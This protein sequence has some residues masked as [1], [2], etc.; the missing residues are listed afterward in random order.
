M[1]ASWTGRDLTEADVVSDTDPFGVPP[2]PHE[3]LASVAGPVNRLLADFLPE[4]SR[5]LAELDPAL[6]PLSDE[7]SAF[8]T[9]GGK[10]LRPA[11]VYWGYRAT[12][13][14]HD[15]GLV[16]PAAAVELF[17]AFA[18]V[19]DDVMD[20]GRQRRGRP[21]VHRNMADYHHRAGL[22]GDSDW[23]GVGAAVVVGDL[24]FVWADALMDRAPLALP[25]VQRAWQ[26]F[27]QLRAEVMAGQYLDLRLAD[28][29]E[30]SEAEALRVTLLKSGRYTVTRPLQLGAA[31][32]DSDDVLQAALA[33]YGDAVGVAF[34]LRDDVLGVFGDPAET[35]KAAAE[36]VREG[37][38][39]PLVV[40]ALEL[41]TP[42]GRRV[43]E[44]ALGEP[45]LDEADIVRVREV[46]VD[47]GALVAIEEMLAGREQQAH[48]ALEPVPEPART[49]LTQLAEFAARRRA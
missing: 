12:G 26:V 1:N 3:P 25:A 16:Y 36:D 23:F 38:R 17:H 37:K 22:S 39:S 5:A 2:D 44:A 20:H 7:L 15:A 35:G 28:L 45:D 14:G 34:Q 6:L 42:K 11:F 4:Q 40:R 32:A 29:P 47:S 8:L 49:A 48:A 43:L 19:H 30:P 33:A 27:T 13:A 21:T 9:S 18:L 41:A 10:R 31:L 24:V 46:V